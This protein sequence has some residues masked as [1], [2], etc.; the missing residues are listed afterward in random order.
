MRKRPSRGDSPPPSELAFLV[1]FLDE[2]TDKPL[3]RI[4]YQKAPTVDP[5]GHVPPAFLADKSIKVALLYVGGYN[6]VAGAPTGTIA[7][8]KTR[9]SMT[10]ALAG[11]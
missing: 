5:V 7:A 10:Q 2:K 1:A 3:F 11:I 9:A 6:N 8:L 4:D